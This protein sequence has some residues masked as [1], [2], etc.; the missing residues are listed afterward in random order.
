MYVL[1][2]L[3][4]KYGSLEDSKAPVS[5]YRLLC[6]GEV[7]NGVV[8]TADWRKSD[9]TRKLLA[10]PCSLAVVSQPFDDY[11]QELSLRVHAPDLVERSGNFSLMFR[12]D[13]DI[14]QDLAALLSVFLR[15]LV[16]V[17]VK[18]R[19]TY[20]TGLP[21]RPP[22]PYDWPLPI[23]NSIT[24]TAWKRRPVS[25][26]YGVRGIEAVIDY[27][28]PPLG[29]DPERLESKLLAAAAVQHS[30][31]YILAARLYAQ[32]MQIIEE[33]PDIAYQLLIS[34]VETVANRALLDYFPPRAEMVETKTQVARRATELGIT[35]NDAEE[36][37]VLACD[38]MGWTSRKFQ[39]FLLAMTDETLWE[40][41]R[42]FRIPEGFEPASGEFERV[43]KE[44]YR[45]RG[46]AVHQGRAAY[47]PGVG[48]GAAPAVP[49]RAM[50]ELFAG[51]P[52]FPPSLGL[53]V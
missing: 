1:D 31:G 40:P 13:D 2:Y 30:E 43:L 32:A 12:P 6:S 7:Y 11:P 52:E 15:R 29:V 46:A 26:G 49:V 14:A 33:W 45:G 8:L 10:R 24:R 21:G 5:E 9:A 39:K 37:A 22:G 34:S 19:V 36:L 48:L 16:T 23:A 51:G 3:A 20:P 41:D 47:G 28:P 50:Q 38:G 53:S 35:A 25:I 4:G 42:L 18:V 17:S 27:N 44:I